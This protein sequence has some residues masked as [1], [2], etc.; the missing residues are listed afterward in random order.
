MTNGLAFSQARRPAQKQKKRVNSQNRPLILLSRSRRALPAA[1]ITTSLT[2]PRKMAVSIVTPTNVDNVCQARSRL[3]NAAAAEVALVAVVAVA[4][5]QPRVL[6]KDAPSSTMSRHRL[7]RR[8]VST[9]VAACASRWDTA[10]TSLAML[11]MPA[12]IKPSTT[13]KS[14]IHDRPKFCLQLWLD[15]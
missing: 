14:E 2:A 8:K 12:R 7:R 11:Q 1:R 10:P 3:D 5:V 6:A 13:P 4:L 15:A 9:T